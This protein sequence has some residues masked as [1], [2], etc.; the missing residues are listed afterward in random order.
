V[1]P[2]SA[3]GALVLNRTCTLRDSFAAEK[4]AQGKGP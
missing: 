4:A 2:D 1:D 3:P